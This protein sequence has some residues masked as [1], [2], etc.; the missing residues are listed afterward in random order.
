MG[1]AEGQG[2]GLSGDCRDAGRPEFAPGDGGPRSD[3]LPL[4]R[5]HVLAAAARQP[6]HDGGAALKAHA[7]RDP[8][9]DHA[10]G[11]RETDQGR[12]EGLA[13]A[14]EGL[15]RWRAIGRLLEAR[16]KR[17]NTMSKGVK[18]A[19]V[20]AYNSGKRITVQEGLMLTSQK[21]FK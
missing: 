20:V 14:G 17:E 12:H 9:R 3:R 15:P 6:E 10:D 4:A 5:Q 18:S 16:D 11:N 2:G 13:Q 8:E 19:F 1:R 7:N 21:W